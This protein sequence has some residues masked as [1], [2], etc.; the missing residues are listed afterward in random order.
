MNTN[1]KL[2]V[3]Y[4]SDSVY[5][6]FDIHIFTSEHFAREYVNTYGDKTDHWYMDTVSEGQDVSFSRDFRLN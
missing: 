6:P 5:E 1:I 3:I 2:Y 4:L